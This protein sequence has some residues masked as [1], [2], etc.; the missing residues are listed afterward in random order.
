MIDP[1]VTVVRVSDQPHLEQTGNFSRRT[2]Y[3]FNV[4][5]FGPFQEIFAATEAAD[6]KAVAERINARVRSL[7]E[8]GVIP[9][10]QV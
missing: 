10:S 7:R 2:T 5:T 4:G 9:Q 3:V 1:T 8:L 6:P